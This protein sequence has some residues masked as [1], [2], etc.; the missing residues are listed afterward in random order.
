VGFN[1][2]WMRH[3]K[4]TLEIL[5]DLRF[6]YHIDDLSHDEPTIIPVC[7]KPFAVVPYTLRN[8]DIARFSNTAMTGAAFAQ[9]LKDEFDVLNAEAAT[10]RRMMSIRLHDRIAGQPT[11]VK[12]MDDFIRYAKQRDGVV[13]MRKDEIARFTLGETNT[14]KIAPRAFG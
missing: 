2:F 6:I 4:S 10:R 9:D 1:A 3:T 14:P 13:F 5:Q 11:V 7:N 8:N 12:A